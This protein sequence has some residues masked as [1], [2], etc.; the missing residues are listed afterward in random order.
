MKHLQIYENAPAQAHGLKVE[1]LELLRAALQDAQKLGQYLAKTPAQAEQL[2]KLDEEK[3][4]AGQFVGTL[5][6]PEVQVDI[7]PKIMQA[8][9]SP[10]EAAQQLPSYLQY[11]L[12]YALSVRRLPAAILPQKPR[13]LSALSLHLMLDFLERYLQKMPY[14]EYIAKPQTSAYL[15]GKL[16]LK[17]YLKKQLARGSW[18]KFS[19]QQNQL[20]TNNHL[21]Q[22]LKYCLS[23]IAVEQPDFRSRVNR[24][25]SYLPE[26][27]TWQSLPPNWQIVALPPNTPEEAFVVQICTWFL[28][29]RLGQSWFVSMPYLFE[30]FLYGFIRQHFP[31]WQVE[32]QSPSFLA[33]AQQHFRVYNDLY[34]P[35]SQQVLE[36]KYK[37]SDSPEA[38]DIYQA[39]S[40]A[41]ARNAPKVCLIYPQNKVQENELKDYQLE[42]EL[43]KASHLHLQVLHLPWL[44]KTRAD[45]TKELDAQIYAALKV[46]ESPKTE[47]K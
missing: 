17:P 45:I 19:S 21:R 4:Q 14:Q 20:S 25:Q 11:Y 31:A 37:L 6:C 29:K 43:L 44:A 46:L 5:R 24:L 18:G 16:A 13:K 1:D 32:R 36:L 30:L 27:D 34:L 42:S 39:I 2:L 3:I 23:Q 38:N 7:L 33:K 40:Y 41:L 22:L 26:V 35:Q 8:T 15:K 10:Q 9:F 28:Q 47:S 12:S